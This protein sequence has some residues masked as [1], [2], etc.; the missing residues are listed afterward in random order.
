MKHGSLK[1]ISR[2]SAILFVLLLAAFQSS[3]YAGETQKSEKDLTSKHIVPEREIRASAVAYS[4]E[5]SARVDKVA[6][7]LD[8]EAAQNQLAQWGI[9]AE[10]VKSAIS[11]LDNADLEYLAAQADNVM[12]DLQGGSRSSRKLLIIGL[13]L[14]PIIIALLIL[15]TGLG[16]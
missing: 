3:T 16:K 9:K 5:R 15:L 14:S 2:L 12:G 8:S 4:A 6:R 13:M 11:R 1:R 7:F 10:Q